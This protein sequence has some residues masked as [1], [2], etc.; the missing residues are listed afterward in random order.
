MASHSSLTSEDRQA[1]ITSGDMFPEFGTLQS[2]RET[3]SLEDK[4]RRGHA[5][6]GTP[7][8]GMLYVG[9]IHR[10]SRWGRWEWSHLRNEAEDTSVM[11]TVPPSR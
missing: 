11:K 5:G 2:R 10:G 7:S 9:Q 3:R 1:T 6:K 8:K 4:R